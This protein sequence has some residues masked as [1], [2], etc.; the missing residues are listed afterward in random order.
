MIIGV[1]IQAPGFAICEILSMRWHVWDDSRAGLNKALGAIMAAAA[2]ALVL[3][4]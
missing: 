2:W 3:R 1:P 4:R